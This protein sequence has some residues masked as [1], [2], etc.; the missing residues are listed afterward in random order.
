MEKAQQQGL[1][2]EEQAARVTRLSRFGLSVDEIVSVLKTSRTFVKDVLTRP[3]QEGGPFSES[4]YA[5][6]FRAYIRVRYSA[7]DRALAPD[8]E[9]RLRLVEI[10][11]KKIKADALQNFLKRMESS[12]R[13]ICS[14]VIPEAFTPWHVLLSAIFVDETREKDGLSWRWVWHDYLVDL[15][16][17][18]APH[19]ESYRA[20]EEELA[21]RYGEV[22]TLSIRPR[23]TDA[24]GALVQERLIDVLRLLSVHNYQWWEVVC[25]HHGLGEFEGSSS[26]RSIATDEGRRHTER[27]R[28]KYIS[29][30]NFLAATLQRTAPGIDRFVCTEKG[31]LAALY[32]RAN[33]ENRRLRE[34]LA[35]ATF[36]EKAAL[37]KLIAELGFSTRTS[38]GMNR[39]G[40]KFVWV[41]VQ[42][43]GTQLLKMRDF[44]EKS[45]EEVNTVLATRGLS[46]GMEF[47][48]QTLAQLKEQTGQ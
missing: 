36:G 35:I 31:E 33:E 45:L 7:A 10:L 42:H 3:N 44:G 43:K 37:V 19:P 15:R 11:E 47:D 5:R 38:N 30:L 4:P 2:A 22:V 17:K 20:A 16:H 34:K 41:L 39:A 12:A 48:A 21:R 9:A 1:I 23:W 46:L 40:I 25:R 8:E 13:R 18:R 26:L 27:V 24:M 14:P 32:V 28:Q 6:S 29:G